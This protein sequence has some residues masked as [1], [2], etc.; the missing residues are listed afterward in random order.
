MAQDAIDKTGEVSRQGVPP[1][2]AESV[3]ASYGIV[4]KDTDLEIKD[5]TGKVLK[6]VLFKKPVFE[7]GDTSPDDKFAAALAFL[8]VLFP[9]VK[10]V[11]GVVTRENSPLNIMLSH[12][13]YSFDLTQRNSIRARV[14]V[15]LEGP[16]KAITKAAQDLAAFQHITLDE[17]L[18]R[19]RALWKV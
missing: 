9:A 1:E 4:L 16:D 6:T 7:D 15:E 8:E 3:A 17:A 14:K 5:G 2:L 11:A 19:V 10:N 18:A 12:L 13:T